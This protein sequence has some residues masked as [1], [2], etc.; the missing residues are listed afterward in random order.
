M[1]REISSSAIWQLESELTRSINDDPNDSIDQYILQED[2]NI[3]DYSIEEDV[4]AGY[5]MGTLDTNKLRLLAGI[6]YEQTD[7]NAR[8]KSYDEVNGDQAISERRFAKN[9]NEML[10]SI[11]LRYSLSKNTQMRMAWSNSLVRPEFDQVR[12]GFSRNDDNEAEFGN[13]ELK[14]L[15]SSNIDFGIEHYVG[16]AS[17]FS[18]FVFYK[19]IKNFTY[20]VDQGEKMASIHNMKKLLPIKMVNPL[21]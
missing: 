1:G 17:A 16:Y 13:P 11:H 7:F 12:P 20:Q 19:D 8:G 5:V 15:Q 2:S 9:N 14:P 18:A 10:P 21:T 6:R 4:L 3:D